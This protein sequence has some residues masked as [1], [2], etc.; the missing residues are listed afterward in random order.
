[1]DRKLVALGVACVVSVSGVSVF[2]L[3]NPYGTIFHFELRDKG[4][5]VG[6]GVV[7]FTLGNLQDSKLSISFVNDTS[8]LYS[9]DVVLNSAAFMNSVFAF[10]EHPSTPDYKILDFEASA[11]T[12]SVNLVL[13]T[14][15]A[16]FL[17]VT[18]TNLTSTVK[19]GNGS[20]LTAKAADW[21]DPSTL[22][23]DASGTFRFEFH[24]DV[25]FT[26]RGLDLQ[27][28]FHGDKPDSVNVNVVLPQG[29]HGWFHYYPQ[30]SISISLGG[31]WMQYTDFCETYYGQSDPGLRM[32]VRGSVITATLS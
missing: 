19:Y 21:V 7:Q 25:N 28:G 31:M 27:V 17:T 8:L 12:R 26:T 13:G 1:M 3:V 24:N 11:A 22:W 14:A 9:L 6:S 29:L 5:A 23:Y 4:T 2:L 16:Y 20:M 30:T 18:G 10:Q 15:K 32:M